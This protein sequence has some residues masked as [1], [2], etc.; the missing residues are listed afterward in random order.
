MI[1][2]HYRNSGNF[3]VRKFRAINFRVKIFS[4]STM[5][6]ENL[7]TTKFYYNE[8]ITHTKIF[9]RPHGAFPALVS[10]RTAAA[11]MEE[12]KRDTCIRGYYIQGSTGGSSLVPRPHLFL[13]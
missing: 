9:F 5:P 8:K 3:R 7:L 6:H 2:V 11:T 12:F 4:W 13:I 1:R 10:D